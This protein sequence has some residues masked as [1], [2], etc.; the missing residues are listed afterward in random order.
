MNGIAFHDLDGKFIY[1]NNAFVKMMGF[2]SD[3]E[4]LGKHPVDITT[5]R[6]RVETIIDAIKN[7]GK[8]FGEDT[9]KRQD[10]SLMC[11][12]ISMS[13]VKDN[14]GKPLMIMASFIDITERKQAEEELRRSEAKY[15]SLAESIDIVIFRAD[16]KT[17]ASTY[18][19]SAVE[20]IYGYT[21]DEWIS[22]PESWAKSIHQDDRDR[23]F[24]EATKAQA[25]MTPFLNEYRIKRKDG[26]VRWVQGQMNWEQVDGNLVSVNGIC[27]DITERKK[28]EEELESAHNKSVQ[29]EKLASVGRLSAGVAHE[30]NNPLASILISVQ[31]LLRMKKIEGTPMGSNDSLRTME[32][33]ERAANQC[34]LIVTELMSFARPIKLQLTSTNINNIV[35]ETLKDLEDQIKAQHVKVEKEFLLKLPK[36]QAD[37]HKLVEVFHN[38]IKNACDAMPEGG[39]LKIITRL[40]QAGTRTKRKAK[41]GAGK[42][43]E[44]EFSDTGEGISEENLKKLF[45]PFFTTKEPGKGVGLGLSIS[46]NI[47]KKHGGTIEASSK[48]G[49]GSTFTVRLPVEM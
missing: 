36:I 39:Q 28:M 24:A 33:I 37:M 40:K 42:A 7:E 12:Q 38:L 32:R 21:V 27:Y 2:K 18:V 46:Y 17:W 31:R 3:K 10:G 14:T 25:E 34:K 4:I 1:A 47:I 16:P 48:K 35:K 49:K 41:D 20:I 23:V 43:V 6:K 44:I 29:S 22:D 45:E 19:N 9:V 11:I 13:L 30:I 8:W 5:D 15:K 26:D